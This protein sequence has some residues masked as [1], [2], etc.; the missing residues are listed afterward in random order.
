MK[1]V[2]LIKTVQK[3]KKN[4][5]KLK[6]KSVKNSSCGTTNTIHSIGEITY[7]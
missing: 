6:I 1:Y 2:I 3:K 7:E 4:K 5:G